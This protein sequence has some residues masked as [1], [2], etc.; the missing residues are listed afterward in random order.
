MRARATGPAA[1]RRLVLI[2]VLGTAAALL[3]LPARPAAAFPGLN[4]DIAFTRASA[5]SWDIYRASN[6]GALARQLTSD[7]AMDSEPAWS[8]AGNKI[9]YSVVESGF[10][11][12]YVM[13]A[14][15][16]DQTNLTSDV[17]SNNTKPTWAPDGSRIAFQSDRDGNWQVYTMK[18]DGSDQRPLMTPGTGATDYAPAWSPDGTRIAFTRISATN[19]PDV[20]VVS[21]NGGSPL[22]LTGADPSEN[23]IP[24]WSPDSSKVAFVSTRDGN[25]E[26]YVTDAIPTN[27][28]EP[29]TRLTT[30]AANDSAPVWSPD[31]KKIAFMSDRDGHW[32]IYVLDVANPSNVT[33]VT[34]GP[35]DDRF[36]DWQPLAGGSARITVANALQPSTDAGRFD[37][38]V[39]STTVWLAAGDGEAGT[40]P[41]DPGIHTVSESGSGATSLG[42]YTTSI[43]CTKNGKADLAGTGTSLDVAVAFGDAEVCKITNTASAP[44]TTPPDVTLD[45]TPPN[46]DDNN[47][48]TFSFSI[49]DPDDN[50]G[51]QASCSL[52]GA[53]P[54]S[55]ISPFSPPER[56]G[57]GSH[58]FEVTATD[59]A[60]NQSDPVEYSWL[61]DTQPPATGVTL[62]S[63]GAPYSPGTWTDKD[64]TVWL[65]C[66]DTGGSGCARTEYELDGGGWTQYG[67]PFT[68]TTVGQHTL[69]YRSLDNAGNVEDAKTAAIWITRAAKLAF[70]TV[71]ADAAS[72]RAFSL[73]PLVA[74]EDGS[75]NVISSEDAAVALSITSGTGAP[76]A[77]LTC[78]AN[79]A[80]AASGLA[81]FSGCAVD[82]AGTGYSLHATAAGLLSAD[83]VAFDVAAPP[84]AH[85]TAPAEGGSYRLNDNVPTSFDCAEG[86]PGPGIASCVD[87]DGA[88]S[89]AGTL[90][91]SRP[92]AFAY[93]ITAISKSGLSTTAQIHYSVIAPQSITFTSTPPADAAYEGT[94]AVK[95]NGGASGN[96]VT[97]SVDALSSPGA[98]LL[99]GAT[100]SFTGV[101]LCVID[102]DQAGSTYYAAAPQAQQSFA[103][104]P[105]GQAITFPAG[106]VTYGQAD[107][108]PASADSGLPLTY[109]NA[110]GPCAID[111]S[112]LVQITGAGSCT[113]T[114]NQAGSAFYRAATPVTQTF[115]IDQAPL[116]VDAS[117]ATVVFGQTPKLT[118]SLDGFVNGENAPSAGVAGA[119]DCQASSPSQHPGTYPGAIT[120]APGTLSAPNYRFIANA[121]GI[122]TIT[123]ESQSISFPAVA[124][125]YTQ[126]DFSPASADSGLPIIYAAP[127]G[128][129]AIDPQGRVQITGAGSCTITAEQP[130]NVDY[131]A[132][133]PVTQTFAIIGPPTARISFP[134]DGQTYTQGQT[135]ST[136]F[137]CSEAPGGPGVSSCT[138]SGGAAGGSGALDTSTPGAHTYSV[139]A[140]S[141]DALT[142]T[143]TIHYTV[144]SSQPRVDH[145][146][147]SS[148]P[149]A[150]AGSLGSG[151]SVDV[152][153]TAVD[154]AGQPVPAAPGMQIFVSLKVAAGGGHSGGPSNATAS[155]DGGSIT[156]AGVFC[157]APAV[158][159]ARFRIHYTSSTVAVR[160]DSDVLTA[161]V[162]RYGS[163]QVEDRY[164][165]PAPSGAAVDHLQWSPDPIAPAGSLGARGTAIT[166]L[167]AYSANGSPI[168]NAPIRLSLGSQTGTSHAFACAD[169]PANGA[170]V[171]CNSGTDGTIQVT[172]GSPSAPPSLGSDALT[173]TGPSIISPRGP[174]PPATA[175]DLYSFQ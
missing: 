97:F 67:S 10:S 131:Q 39:D 109:S 70:V 160:G 19:K 37:L 128:Q 9:A 158:G 104:A 8:P 1:S 53:A 163:E 126:P 54:V 7:P 114:A 110:I 6:G 74:V 155:C 121:S 61:I 152:T 125:L 165:Y 162:D 164:F 100:A 112:G 14:D 48:P 81:G 79:P 83:S 18:P 82:L 149:V 22:N 124:V 77:S 143:T 170:A 29:P 140:A 38:T 146:V 66:A 92:G 50:A 3:I 47:Q 75:G 148:S 139:T 171:T 32:Q 116:F 86:I 59:A 72:G 172:Y 156:A 144:V 26:I 27:P 31:G 123:P 133:S 138:D 147:W 65:A 76:G 103:I 154:G 129:C 135:V 15:G 130:G 98:C 111:P 99:S 127:S 56:L 168:P 169:I 62:A 12:V 60:G 44:D 106:A 58:T 43:S 118:Y 117:D 173:A 73:Q 107:F 119:A 36:P 175:R 166:T 49:S 93:T 102:A 2:V 122:L 64:V 41:V 33:R 17:T 30:N 150:P 151:G 28:P 136:S 20:L 95:A 24:S 115:T 25:Q 120:C 174:V 63:P 87:G 16:S 145:L 132:A 57:D 96:A 51:F 159:A 23:S 34:N 4:G 45:E 71:P 80:S 161:A 157:P 11:N 105:A 42:D 69:R 89:P 85:V 141:Q 94:Y 13:N 167:T 142:A 40:T 21:A 84:V 55:C 5:G 108:S 134:A 91:T 137:S 88:S 153:V 101:G 52:D 68:L 46:P 78:D 35:A 113:I 90:D